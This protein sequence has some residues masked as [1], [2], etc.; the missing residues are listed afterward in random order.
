MIKRFLLYFSLFSSMLCS[1]QLVSAIS[2][3]EVLKIRLGMSVEE[4][5]KQLKKIGKLEREERKQQ[6]IWT[7]VNHPNYSH[8]I[9]AFDKEYKKVRFV[10]AKVREGGNHVRYSDVIDVRKAVKENIGNN[11]K[12]VLE[13]PAKGKDPGYVVT[14]RGQDAEYLTYFSMEI[15][16]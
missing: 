13:V 10:T 16:D 3:P 15:K 11:Y 7:L 2:K 9:V 6:E 1:V 4:A 14:A 8:L 5:H 12:Y